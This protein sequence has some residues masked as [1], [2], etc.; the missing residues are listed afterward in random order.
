MFDP[1]ISMPLSLDAAR[2]RAPT[3]NPATVA[4]IK[5]TNPAPM[6]PAS[7]LLAASE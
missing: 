2:L 6:I 4:T 3:R 5:T 1:S 7:G